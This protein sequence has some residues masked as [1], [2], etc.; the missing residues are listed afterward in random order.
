MEQTSLAKTR[1]GI[2]GRMRKHITTISLK[3]FIS[4]HRIEERHCSSKALTSRGRE[5][6]ERRSAASVSHFSSRDS[7]TSQMCQ[8]F[9]VSQH[10]LDGLCQRLTGPLISRCRR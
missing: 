6:L 9:S 5:A 2:G 4:S 1:D 7:L 3:R 8:E 10:G